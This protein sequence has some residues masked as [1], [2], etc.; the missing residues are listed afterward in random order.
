MNSKPEISIA[1]SFQY[2]IPL[3]NQL[4]FIAEA[5]FSN[6][7]LGANLEHSGCL[8]PKRRKEVKSR[9]SEH[10]LAVDTIHACGLNKPNAVAQIS[11]TAEAAVE[12][13]ASCIVAHVGGRLQL[14]LVMDEGPRAR[15]IKGARLVQV[16]FFSHTNKSVQGAIGGEAL[17]KRISD[18]CEG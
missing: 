6:V 4:P 10:G 3:E 8:D 17:E 1:S 18:C 16:A 2:N 14:D 13:E 7:S 11:A 15:A 12:F 5:G 9:L